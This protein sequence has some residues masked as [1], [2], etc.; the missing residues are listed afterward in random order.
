VVH[1]ALSCKAAGRNARAEAAGLPFEAR[2]G[3]KFPRSGFRSAAQFIS[4]LG[5]YL[6]LAKAQRGLQAQDEFNA[7]M[8]E[9]KA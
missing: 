4:V 6:V 8:R 2:P 1:T 3:N 5:H 9:L 7:K